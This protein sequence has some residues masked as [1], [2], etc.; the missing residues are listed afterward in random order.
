[1]NEALKLNWLNNSV[2][3][4][5]LICDAPGH[6]R[7]LKNDLSSER[8]NYP[9][10][11]PDGFK[12]QEQIKIFAAKNINF[13]IVKVNKKCDTMIKVMQENYDSPSLKINVTDLADAVK[14]KTSAEVT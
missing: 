13:T 5:F 1:L 10:G 9:A 7:D 6:G 8:D 3:Q 12:I 11:S 14:N 4:A 2:K